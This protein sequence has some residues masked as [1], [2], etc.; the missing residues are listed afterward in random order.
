[1]QSGTM[2]ES[3]HRIAVLLTIGSEIAGDRLSAQQMRLTLRLKRSIGI[4]YA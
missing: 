2:S 1:M 3:S 4:V